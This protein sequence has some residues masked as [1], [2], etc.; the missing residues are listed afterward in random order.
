MVADNESTNTVLKSNGSNLLFSFSQMLAHHSINGCP[1]AT[2]DLLGSGT[3]SGTES[4]SEGSLLELSKGGKETVKLASGVERT[5]LEDGDLVT[6]YGVCGD[7]EGGF[8]GF[9]E[10][11]GKILPAITIS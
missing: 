6:I 5:F 7:E 2:G 10:C 4:G 11:S 3:I 1:M 8:V 9:G